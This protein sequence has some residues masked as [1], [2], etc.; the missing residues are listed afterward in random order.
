MGTAD[1]PLPACTQQLD[2]EVELTVV[3]G[4]KA[5]NVSKDDAMS[6]VLGYTVAHDVSA[7]DWQMKRNGGHGL[8]LPNWPGH[9]HKGGGRRSTQLEPLVYCQ[10]SCQTG[11]EHEAVGVWCGRGGLLDFPIHHPPARR[12]NSHRHST[13]CRGLHEASRVPQKGRH[14]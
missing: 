2:W 8:I 4:Q 10:R 6:Y 13:R 14:R 5:S 12:Y 1:L 3:I 9:C 7:R 11:F